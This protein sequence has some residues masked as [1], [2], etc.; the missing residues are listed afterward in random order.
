MSSKM[1]ITVFAN[2]FSKCSKKY[3]T[4]SIMKKL[5][6]LLNRNFYRLTLR[7]MLNKASDILAEKKIITVSLWLFTI[8]LNYLQN[9]KKFDFENEF[10]NEEIYHQSSF[11]DVIYT[12]TDK[13]KSSDFWYSWL[14]ESNSISN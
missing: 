10:K 6:H 4:I 12:L 2:N 8:V 3:L 13:F 11:K 1:F 9:L 5:I 14:R 7:K